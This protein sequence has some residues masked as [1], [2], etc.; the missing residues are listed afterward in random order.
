MRL[1]EFFLIKEFGDGAPDGRLLVCHTIGPGAKNNIGPELNGIDGRSPRTYRMAS[2][3]GSF[4][5]NLAEND[6]F[7]TMA[8]KRR[9]VLT[10]VHR[11]TKTPC[12]GYVCIPE[13]I[14]TADPQTP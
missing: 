1:S 11:R 9:R 14:E 8:P 6:T 4:L 10:L 5:Q 13:E 2:F 3:K 12:Y 7:K